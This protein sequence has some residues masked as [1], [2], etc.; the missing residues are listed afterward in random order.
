MSGSK[1]AKVKHMDV[2]GL[3]LFFKNETFFHI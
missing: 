3:S 1:T 2:E